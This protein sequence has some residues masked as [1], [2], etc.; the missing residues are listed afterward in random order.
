MKKFV[1]FTITDITKKTLSPFTKTF[2]HQQAKTE[3]TILRQNAF[4]NRKKL[5]PPVSSKKIEFLKKQTSLLCTI[6]G[7]Q[8]SILTF[9]LLL[10]TRKKETFQVLYCQHLWQIKNFFSARLVF[11]LSS[12][13][14][15]PYTL[16]LPQNLVIT[17]N[18]SREW[19]KKN[20]YRFSHM[21]RIL[22]S[23]TGHTETDTLEKN[24]NNI[25]RGTSPAGLDSFRFV[26]SKNR[27]ALLFSN[28]NFNRC[29]FIK[30]EKKIKISRKFFFQNLKKKKK[31]C[32]GKENEVFD[33]NGIFFFNCIFERASAPNSR[34][35][36]LFSILEKDL[37]KN[38][39]YKKVRLKNPRNQ[40]QSFCSSQRKKFQ[41]SK[42]LKPFDPYPMLA[43]NRV[44]QQKALL[45]KLAVVTESIVNTSS[46]LETCK[47]SLTSIHFEKLGTSSTI[48]SF[49]YSTKILPQNKKNTISKQIKSCSFCFSEESFKMPVNLLKPLEKTSRFSVSKLVN[50]YKL[51]LLVDVTNFSSTFS[52]NKIRHQLI[53]F[54]RSLVHPNV[55]Y[56]L[57]NF[58]KMIS[59]EHQERENDFLEFYFI[60]KLLILKS[61]KKK[62]NLVTFST[63]RKLAR[64]SLGS[65]KGVIPR[66]GANELALRQTLGELDSKN[67]STKQLLKNVSGPQTR[68]LIQ[69]LFFEYK[70]LTLNYSQ[71]F[72]L[73]DF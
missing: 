34:N 17:E 38:G 65:K 13:V 64:F 67:Y 55:E 53:P 44:E 73:H 33:S 2:F 22:T 7:G 47:K 63:V 31:L 27:V 52:R 28:L 70:N 58:F 24:L 66:S 29:F 62:N 32:I 23:M 43:L 12:L 20:F 4:F 9:F 57:M 48:F 49:F 40:N 56:L 37:K 26:N 61:R 69:K 18:E 19:R 60:Y 8:D 35:L 42:P 39:L 5:F 72:K 68:S 45:I 36:V 6:S 71:I 54:I 1:N 51:P 59:E 46:L 16:I 21:A 11:Q 15:V 3:K 30:L 41:F 14:K 50:L 25:L 10:H